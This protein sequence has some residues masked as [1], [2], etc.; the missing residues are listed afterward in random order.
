[1]VFSGDWDLRVFLNI[2]TKYSY[3][4]VL[5]LALQFNVHCLRLPSGLVKVDPL[6]MQFGEGRRNDCYSND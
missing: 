2:K 4:N 3:T 6:I 5:I 1:M